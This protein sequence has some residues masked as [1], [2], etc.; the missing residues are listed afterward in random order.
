MSETPLDFEKFQTW[1]G[2]VLQTRGQDILRS[3]GILDFDGL[4][5][6]YVF[7]GVHMLMDASPMGPWPKDKE[8]TSRVVFIGRN[9]DTMDL[10]RGLEGCK[11][12]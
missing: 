11:S 4:D 1:F 6:R 10:E 7:Q 12:V 9:L 5:E 8:K 2:K 3:K